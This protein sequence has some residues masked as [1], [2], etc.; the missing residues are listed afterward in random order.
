MHVMMRFGAVWWHWMFSNSMSVYRL[1][2]WCGSHSAVR[3]PEVKSSDCKRWRRGWKNLTG[4]ALIIQTDVSVSV[5]KLAAHSDSPHH[6]HITRGPRT[7]P[8]GMTGGTSC[9]ASS[10]SSS[11]WCPW[12]MTSGAAS[13]RDRG[14]LQVGYFANTDSFCS[15][16]NG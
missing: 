15:T 5:N 7:W 16:S 6:S 1:L 3:D 8:T 13:Q 9:R 2:V 4:D 14:L 11:F 10:D 12:R